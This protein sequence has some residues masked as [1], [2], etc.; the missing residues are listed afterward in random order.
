MLPRGNNNVEE[1]NKGESFELPRSKPDLLPALQILRPGPPGPLFQ[2][3]W[4]WK[5]PAQMMLSHELLKY[6]RADQSP[7]RAKP[8]RNPDR[9]HQEYALYALRIPQRHRRVSSVSRHRETRPVSG[10]DLVS[11]EPLVAI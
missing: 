4:R 3:A 8:R 10:A 1:V 6:R 11:P 5:H 9:S 7:S 2:T